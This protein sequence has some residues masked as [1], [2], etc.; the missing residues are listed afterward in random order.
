[1]IVVASLVRA[2]LARGLT[3]EQIADVL[4]ESECPDYQL[5]PKSSAALRQQRYRERKSVTN[6]TDHNA[7]YA[8]APVTK[9]NTSVTERNDVTPLARGE[10]NLL[11]LEVSGKEDTSEAKAS[12][13]S[14]P[15]RKSGLNGHQADFER[16]WLVYPRRLDRGHAERAFPKAL[17][18]TDIDTL[19]RTTL[20]FAAQVRDCDPRHIAHGA[21]WLNG[22][23]WLDEYPDPTIVPFGS[24]NAEPSISSKLAAKQANMA[25]AFTGAERV[26]ARKRE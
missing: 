10:D 11:K 15:K 16:W 21:T 6:V 23:R 17:A 8:D 19:I 22:K 9:R 2:L 25:R 5:P 12:S 26:F 14:P 3:G 4:Q 13:V 24:K 18:Q 20:A 1:M 7:R